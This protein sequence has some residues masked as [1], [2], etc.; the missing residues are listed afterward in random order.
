MHYDAACF[1][2]EFLFLSNFLLSYG[3]TVR[4]KTVMLKVCRTDDILKGITIR[5]NNN[6]IIYSP[7]EAGPPR[8]LFWL[9][10]A[11]QVSRAWS[12]LVRTIAL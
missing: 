11:D 12:G 8:Y 2:N 6:V 5:R 4:P 10:L 1:P 3:L 7:L 9:A